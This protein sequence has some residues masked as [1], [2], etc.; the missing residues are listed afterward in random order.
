M[1]NTDNDFRW[2]KVKNGRLYLAVVNLSIEKNEIGNEIVEN[3]SGT[4]YSNHSIDVGKTECE[5]WKLGL[6]KGLEFALLK[7]PHFFTITINGLEGRPLMDTNPTIIGY[8]G[9]LAFLKQTNIVIEDEVLQRLEEYVFRSW[10]ADN[11]E[12]IPDFNNLM[13][14]KIVIDKKLS[15]SFFTRIKSWFS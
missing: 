9:I 2:M 14:E 8:T 4:G 3:Y 13:L 7:S 1:R 11:A 15:S 12:K 5:D 6:R 10:E